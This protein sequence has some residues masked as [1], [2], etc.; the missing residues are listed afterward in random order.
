MIYADLNSF[1]SLS[2]C[3]VTVHVGAV[4]EPP[5]PLL[6][7][8]ALLLALYANN[9]GWHRGY[10]HSVYH[11]IAQR[12]TYSIIRGKTQQVSKTSRVWVLFAPI[13]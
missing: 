7:A 11:G 8:R 13:F 2:F 4:R 12:G 3:V 9:R 5:L 10:S 1:G 6:V